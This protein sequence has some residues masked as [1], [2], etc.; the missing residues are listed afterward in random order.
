MAWD[1]YQKLR[2]RYK[3][4]SHGRNCSP[5]ERACY[6]KELKEQKAEKLQSEIDQLKRDKL[7]ALLEDKGG[8]RRSR[9]PAIIDEEIEGYA[10]R[11]RRLQGT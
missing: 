11:L 10:D 9:I 5:Q 2:S 4:R 1:Q 6:H 7:A 3:G 8:Q